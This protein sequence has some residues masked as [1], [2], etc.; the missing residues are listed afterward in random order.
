MRC[1]SFLAFA[2][3]LLH[4]LSS[5]LNAAQTVLVD[6]FEEQ[7]LPIISGNHRCPSMAK[8]SNGNIAVTYQSDGSKSGVFFSLYDSSLNKI[9]SD[10]QVNQVVFPGANSD[11]V[12]LGLEYTAIGTTADGFIVAYN[13]YT[14][15]PPAQFFVCFRTYH[16]NGTALSGEISLGIKLDKY[17]Q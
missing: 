11:G 14:Q 1:R 8:L 10:R 6:A 15:T 16:L 17:S 12:I 5:T 2:L 13:P 9:I 7:A 3:A 4:L